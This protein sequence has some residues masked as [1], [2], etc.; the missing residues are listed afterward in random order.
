[1]VIYSQYFDKL[2]VP[3]LTAALKESTKLFH[4]DLINREIIN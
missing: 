4:M 2:G 1:M 3:A